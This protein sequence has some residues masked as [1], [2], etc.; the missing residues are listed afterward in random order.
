M[1]F[2][3]AFTMAEI[4]VALF[5][6]G[7]AFIP[8]FNLYN[9]SSRGTSNNIN[10]IVATNYASDLINCVRD[11]PYRT[12]KKIVEESVKGGEK[13][14]KEYKENELDDFFSNTNSDTPQINDEGKKS[15]N[16]PY[17]RHLKITHFHGEP[18]GLLATLF[19]KIK[20]QQTIPSYL[21]TVSV[22]FPSLSKKGK[23]K[24]VLYSVVV[25]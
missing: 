3:K 10:E 16:V 9:F 24:V 19:S 21:I 1:F 13:K 23:E 11:I 17:E 2:K 18:E 14:E 6:I 4:A 22:D 25:E 8:M 7:C 20:K 15:A 12:L 5:V